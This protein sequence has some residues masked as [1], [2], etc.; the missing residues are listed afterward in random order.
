MSVGSTVFQPLATMYCSGACSLPA[1][2]LPIQ[3]STSHVI[4]PAYAKGAELY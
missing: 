4:P 2:V 1:H 3:L